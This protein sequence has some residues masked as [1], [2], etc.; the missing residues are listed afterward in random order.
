MNTTEKLRAAKKLIK[1]KRNWCKGFF[2][3][4]G[5][6]CAFGALGHVAPDRYHRASSCLDDA[7]IGMGYDCGMDLNDKGTHA[8]VMKMF[9]R[10][11]YASKKS[12]KK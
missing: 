7:A 10:A 11:I 2:E 4:K 5:K 3:W 8:L 6:H 1:D 9:D 12:E